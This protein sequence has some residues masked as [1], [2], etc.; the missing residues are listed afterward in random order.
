MQA[1]E[2]VEIVKKSAGLKR[3][4]AV[5]GE[6]FNELFINFP[7]TKDWKIYGD[8]A[9]IIPHNDEFLL[10]S[11]DAIMSEFIVTDPFFAGRSGVLA[12]VNDIYCMGGCPIAIVNALVCADNKMTK[13]IVQGM[14]F[15]SNEYKVP[16]VGGHFNSYDASSSPS[17]VVAIIGRAESVLRGF[18][19]QEGQ[20]L[21]V[22]TSLEGELKIGEV[23]T[24]NSNNNLTS[25]AL[26]ARL[27]VIPQIAKKKYATCCKDISAGGLLGTTAIMLENSRVG[28]IIDLDSI[29]VPKN[30]NFADWILCFQSYGF[31]LSV[32]PEH[33]QKVLKM[34]ANAN[35][36]AARIGKVTGDR[37]VVLKKGNQTEILFDF[38]RDKITGI[39]KPENIVI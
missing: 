20:D 7:H 9:A 19:A 31:V 15:A 21:V 37:T 5:I 1:R 12:C 35:V 26:L 17:L 2:I 27:E 23:Y 6:I 11:T 8:D 14:K 16:I 18:Q 25:E 34:F 38:F 29:P 10:F 33:T 39:V 24:W 22:A 4:T 36:T 28:A 3:K 30:S 13:A 32:K